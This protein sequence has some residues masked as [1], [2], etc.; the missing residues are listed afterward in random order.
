M[1]V[2]VHVSVAGHKELAADLEAV[3][4]R[5]RAERLRVLAT[6]GLAA[7]ASGVSATPSAD[8]SGAGGSAG[9]E[10]ARR[11]ARLLEKLGGSLSS[12]G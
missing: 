6:L 4:P 3:P 10:A 9:D 5:E 8:G 12:S 2:V 1:R 11:R 7:L